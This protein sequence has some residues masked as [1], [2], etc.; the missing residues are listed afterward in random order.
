MGIS[1]FSKRYLLMPVVFAKRNGLRPF[2]MSVGKY[3]RL[4]GENRIAC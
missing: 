2:N 3:D 1:K 4:L